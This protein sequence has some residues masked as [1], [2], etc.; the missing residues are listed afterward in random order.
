MDIDAN[1][2]AEHEI[3]NTFFDEAKEN[4]WLTSETAKS[5]KDI[6]VRFREERNVIKQ[7]VKRKLTEDFA[8]S[9]V[10]H[11]AQ[12]SKTKSYLMKHIGELSDEVD[13]H[14]HQLAF[15]AKKK[16]AQEDLFGYLQKRA[17]V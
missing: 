5:V 8:N 9:T 14:L 16:F 17:K 10:H 11:A 2:E 12:L 13:L 3:L 6:K 7:Q 1:M 4:A 15:N